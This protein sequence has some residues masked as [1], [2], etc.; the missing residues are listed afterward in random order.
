MFPILQWL[1]SYRL[2]WFRKDVL[3]GVTVSIMLV[4]QSL[5]YA[6]LAGLPPEWG[7][8][9]AIS[10]LIVYLF[11]GTSPK[12]AVGPVA[13]TSIMVASAVEAVAGN[14]DEDDPEYAEKYQRIAMTL[15]FVTGIV[16]LI[17]GALRAGF[18]IVFLSD[19]VM[20]GFIMSAA[21]IIVVEQ[22]GALLGLDIVSCVH[23]QIE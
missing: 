6:T 13:T 5:A 8:Y 10:P 18:I 17:F 16:L 19:P 2:S 7:L 11:M 1:P 14:G 12:L 15:T 23:S 21:S 9:A 20:I 3:S 22:L 4:P